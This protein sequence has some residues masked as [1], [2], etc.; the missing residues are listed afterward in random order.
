MEMLQVK[1]AAD[2]LEIITKPV[3][4]KE[5]KEVSREAERGSRTGWLKV[6]CQLSLERWFESAALK[7]SL[8]RLT[9]ILARNAA[10]ID[11]LV[12]GDLAERM[13]ET[14]SLTGV[15]DMDEREERE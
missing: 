10:D 1:G 13:M 5:A 15:I 12:N 2:A 9:R 7:E 8:I 11:V 3:V 6:L 4:S 14:S